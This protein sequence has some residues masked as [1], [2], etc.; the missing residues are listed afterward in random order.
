L[1]LKYD[2]LVLAMKFFPASGGSATYG[3]NLAWGLKKSGLNIM[4]LAP[5]YDN[6]QSDDS[7][8]PF[9]VHR[10]YFTNEKYS[11]IR[12]LMAAFYILW[13]C[14]KYRPKYIWAST[15]AGCSVLGMVSFI[16][17]K[18]IGTIHGGGIH[19][20]FPIKKFSDRPGNYF[21]IR[22]IRRC[23]ALITVSEE[24]KKMILN[25]LTP[26][27]QIPNFH[28]IYNGIHLDPRKF[29]TKD[30]AL[31]CYPDYK[32]KRILLT[33]GRLV[34]AKGHELVIQA[35]KELTR[36]YN[37]LIYIIIGEGPEKDHLIQLTKELALESVVHFKGYITDEQLEYFYG[38]SDVFIMAGRETDHFI[39]G[40]GLVYIE[41]GIR[42]K[43]V[44]GTR[45]G[46]IP[47]AIVEN[48]TG[49]IAEPDNVNDIVSAIK[50]LFE[51][52]SLCTAMSDNAREF[53]KKNF[54]NE[55]MAKHNFE[56]L[57]KI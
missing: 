18:M 11:I 47:E 51:N 14:Y 16:K 26:H 23:D 36:Q 3:F 44:I 49:L 34:R 37:D 10:M 52:P 38:L 39:E 19:R 24:S 48:E 43:P 41:A 21:G 32:N 50:K 9:S 13:A 4:V 22:F 12:H 40:F 31:S 25:R 57:E 5:S 55:I 42:G 30:E 29:V 45:V 1:Q 46:G 6:R 2:V 17:S 8:C 53:V 20:R 35:V 54:T 7:T 28:V 27:V 56:L 15:F 33:V